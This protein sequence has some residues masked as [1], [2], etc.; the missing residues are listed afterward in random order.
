MVRILIV[1][2]IQQAPTQIANRSGATAEIPRRAIT[3]LAVELGRDLGRT[4]GEGVGLGVDLGEIPGADLHVAE[5]VGGGAAGGGVD[6][7]L[8]TLRGV[9]G[10][11]AEVGAFEQDRAGGVA[12]EE[13]LV[14]AVEVFRLGLR[15][16]EGVGD[17]GGRVVPECRT[18]A[19]LPVAFT[20]A[21]GPVEGGAVAGEGVDVGVDLSGDDDVADLVGLRDDVGVERLETVIDYGVE[22]GDF[23]C[24][25]GVFDEG[26]ET[27]EVVF[28]FGKAGRVVRFERRD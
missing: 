3:R 4:I 17:A 15:V 27:G 26:E 7:G 16:V 23:A 6:D 19:V 22:V 2:I 11:G 13:I 8:G 5:A 24:Q 12:V 14:V 25:R 10:L 1:L 20:A 18:L 9:G 28:G 21:C